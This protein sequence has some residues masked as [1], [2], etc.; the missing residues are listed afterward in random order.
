[1]TSTRPSAA[2]EP[3]F[4]VPPTPEMCR[5]A[6]RL[7]P[8][9]G[10]HPAAKAIRFL[11]VT[12]LAHVCNRSFEYQVFQYATFHQSRVARVIHIVCMPLIACSALALLW[13]LSWGLGAV[14]SLA[15]PAWYGWQAHSN[16]L[17]TLAL[18]NTAVG[19]GLGVSA[20]A[21][22]GASGGADPLICCLALAGLEA[23]SHGAEPA[24]PPRT[25]GSDDWIPMRAWAW[26]SESKGRPARLGA[27]FVRSFVSFF[28]GTA[29]EVWGSWRLLPIVVARAAFALGLHAEW[30]GRLQRHI[31][32]A[33]AS[34]NPAL[35]AIG[36]GGARIRYDLPGAPLA[37]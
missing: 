34:G 7:R 9:Y 10:P 26:G 6:Q 27:A 32:V 33:V 5:W 25:N 36:I 20:W 29:N 8:L 35:E 2:T 15:L 23:I 3:R 28:S 1:M 11:L 37:N 31:D 17:S 13:Q 21:W 30:A 22:A 24:A 18:I 14:V 16:G 4:L 12:P 19:V